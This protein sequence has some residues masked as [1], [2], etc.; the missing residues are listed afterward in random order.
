VLL[1]KFGVNV[2][3]TVFVWHSGLFIVFFFVH[4]SSA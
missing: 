4:Y 3:P 2:H 1:V